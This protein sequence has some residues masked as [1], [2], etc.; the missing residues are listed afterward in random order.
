MITG[1]NLGITGDELQSFGY[2][3]NLSVD[4]YK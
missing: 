2:N 1:R 3:S 4:D